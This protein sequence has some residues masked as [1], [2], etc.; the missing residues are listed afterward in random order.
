MTSN[1]V[2]AI[3]PT[4]ISD[5]IQVIVTSQCN[6]ILDE[7]TKIYPT[8]FH[9][10]LI[11]DKATTECEVRMNLYNILGQVLIKNRQIQNGV[12]EINVSALAAG[13]YFCIFR[14]GDK[15]L[16]TEK[17]LKAAWKY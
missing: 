8:P 2:C 12:N 5:S 9:D 3:P 4:A 1:A 11:I 10:I 16:R 15:V 13:M 17:I 7:Q 6:C 14:S